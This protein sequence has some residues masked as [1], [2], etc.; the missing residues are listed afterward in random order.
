[1]KA[2]LLSLL[3]ITFAACNCPN[4]LKYDLTIRVVYSQGVADTLQ[5]SRYSC[6]PPDIELID[7]DLYSGNDRLAY[8]VRAFSILSMTTGN[9]LITDN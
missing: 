8:D 9:H 6:Y 7:R 2:L 3:F 4:P 5:Y 1:M